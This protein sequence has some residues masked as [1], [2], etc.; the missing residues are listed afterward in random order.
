MN[1]LRCNTKMKYYQ[2]DTHIAYQENIRKMGRFSMSINQ[3]P[4]S[5]PGSYVC[6]NCGY[7]ELSMHDHE[8]A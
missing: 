4:H 8:E 1:C 5:I 3:Q 2:L 6:E 7:V